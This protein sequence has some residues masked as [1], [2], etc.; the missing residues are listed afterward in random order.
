MAKL[1]V[2]LTGGIGSGKSAV[3]EVFHERGA[4]V[5]DADIIAREVV[6]PGSEGLTEIARVWPE[7]IA[8]DGSLDRAAMARIV[9]AD[10][11]ARARLNAITHP[12]VRARAAA[13]DEAVSDG[14]VVHVVPLLFEGEAWRGMDRTVVVVAPDEVRIARVVARDRAGRADVERRIAAQIDPALARRRADYV[15]EN[16]GPLADLR[17]RAEEVVE[18]LQRELRAK[19]GS[20]T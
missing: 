19:E 15:I 8:A 20:S 17:R 12:R 4:T 16:D 7:T 13:L 9:F 14:I 10:E 2:G 3:A 11:A 18:A 1:R 6:A 5:V